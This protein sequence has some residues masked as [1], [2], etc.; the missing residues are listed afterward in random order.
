MYG[1]TIQYPAQGD[2]PNIGEMITHLL[3]ARSLRD[4]CPATSILR[5]QLDRYCGYLSRELS[6]ALGRSSCL[7]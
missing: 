4:T 1:V 6:T 5:D 7:R 2:E 3:E